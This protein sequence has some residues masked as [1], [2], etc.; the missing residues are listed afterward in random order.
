MSNMM[1]ITGLATGLDTDTMVKQMMQPYTMK[2]DKLKQERQIIQWKQDLYRDIIGDVN[3][4]RST[5]FDVLKPETY[6]LSS[7]NYSSFD[8]KYSNESNAVTATTSSG[9]V[10]GNYKVNV[11]QL[12]EKA[13]F[14]GANTVNVKE[15]VSKLTFPI[16][17]DGQNNKLT[18][19]GKSINDLEIK[20]YS[21][22][23][24]LASEINKKMG[25]TVDGTGKLS[26]S[27][28]AVVKDDKIEFLSKVSIKDT[29]PDINNILEV[30]INSKVYKLTI[31]KG[32][33]TTSDLA[34]K[35]NS[36]LVGAKAEDGTVFDGNGKAESVDGATITFKDTSQAT[37]TGTSVKYQSNATEVGASIPTVTSITGA[38]GSRTGSQAST[39]VNTL[40]YR[41][42][43]FSGIN[44]K[45]TIKKGATSYE[46]SLTDLLSDIVDID[47]KTSD[48]ITTAVATKL[49]SKLSTYGVTVDRSTDGKLLFKSNG[50]EQVS[51]SGNG[52]ATLGLTS[53]F[54]LNQ[55]I[56]DKMSN[57]ISG[58][59]KFSINNVTFHYD[60]NSSV[61]SGTE[62]D[63]IIGAKNKSITD[64][65]GEISSKANVDITY[66]QLTKKFS[67]SSKSTGVDQAIT[68]TRDLGVG[69][70]INT[71][72]G[73]SIISDSNGYKYDS[74]GIIITPN[75][76]LQG[77]DAIVTITEPNGPDITVYKSTNSFT[78]DGVNFT[79]NAKTLA[80]DGVT[81]APVTMTLTANATKTFDQIKGF[82]N[83]YNEMIE[84]VGKKLEET[85]AR[86]GSYDKYLPLT[87][88]QKKEMKD[89]DI[90]IWEDKAKQGLLRND[91]DL[92]NMLTTM[93]NAFY[94][95]V[96]GAGI[97]LG[98]IGLSTS[99]DVSQR[100][101]IVIDE[102]KLKAAIQNNGD[103]VAS[104][105]MKVSTNVPSYTADLSNQQ[106]IDRNSDQGIFQRI[107]DILLDNVRTA[108]NTSGKKGVLL[109][110]A[111]I[112][113]DFTEFQNILGEQLKTKDVN[114]YSLMDK[115]SDKENK[116]YIQ[117]S[118]LE[119]AMQQMNSQSNWLAQQLGAMG[120]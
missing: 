24:D 1:R 54:D 35:I 111:G 20:T 96:E 75:E 23:Y 67:M 52:T 25:A 107:N 31:E 68:N 116:F 105:F 93:R 33:Y 18:V 28:Q 63:K 115:L 100:G 53:N 16:K 101:K 81:S 79:L 38:D 48:E 39:S 98:E 4:F 42:E 87:D 106:R 83:K 36:K 50:N 99:A 82:I 40:S 66:S 49:G 92:S 30:T 114:I 84:K 91:N 47:T 19:D 72:F 22:L 104:I 76:K 41:E 46:V 71:I 119:R 117:F 8:I 78:M 120:G 45:L 51:I 108:R 57:L 88:E 14:S 44:D 69:N 59:V 73:Q 27:F 21:N 11:A 15:A 113:G 2:L 6:M 32:N 86:S 95:T 64:I 80:A 94:T 58:E 55:S 74:S 60:F 10:A 43:I 118:K 89:E 65:L 13:S 17:I 3:T 5:Y 56:G 29:E 85:A 61:D 97:S 70:F 77:K 26:E 62:A 34:A 112:K 37:M 103:K 102:T 90:K 7:K 109:E 12:A 110:K 9:A